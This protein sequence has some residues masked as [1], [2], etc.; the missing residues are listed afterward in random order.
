MSYD[1]TNIYLKQYQTYNEI[2]SIKRHFHC[3]MDESF[4]YWQISNCYYTL[5]KIITLLSSNSPTYHQI[6]KGYLQT[7]IVI[8]QGIKRDWQILKSMKKPRGKKK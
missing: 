5:S 6:A 8:F 4:I 1:P 2:K 7:A 3:T